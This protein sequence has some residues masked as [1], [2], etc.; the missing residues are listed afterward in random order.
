MTE[1][2]TQKIIFV[3]VALSV[4]MAVL[5]VFVF[6][7]LQ[8]NMHNDGECMAFG[9]LVSNCG[10]LHNSVALA[11]HHISSLQIFSEITIS[12]LVIVFSLIILTSLIFDLIY[13]LQK[14][15]GDFHFSDKEFSIV[16]NFKS[17]LIEWLSLFN[18]RYSH[19][20]SIGCIPILVVN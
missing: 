6:G 15:E 10:I 8:H 17:K 3:G 1:R 7:F 20:F 4:L 13:K 14:N 16:Y 5:G 11:I 18:K 19:L 2:K 12:S 9:T